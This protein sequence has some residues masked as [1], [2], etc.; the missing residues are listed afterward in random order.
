[1]TLGQYLLA[2][3]LKQ[4]KIQWKWDFSCVSDYFLDESPRFDWRLSMESVFSFTNCCWLLATAKF[5]CVRV[6]L[7]AYMPISVCAD[8]NATSKKYV[9][10]QFS[11]VIDG[12]QLK[13]IKYKFISCKIPSIHYNYHVRTP[14]YPGSFKRFAARVRFE[15]NWKSIKTQTQHNKMPF[16]LFY[17][18]E[19]ASTATIVLLRVVGFVVAFIWKFNSIPLRCI[20]FSFDSFYMSLMFLTFQQDARYMCRRHSIRKQS[21]SL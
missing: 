21:S 5:I 19:N 9:N 16:E 4:H 2:C 15:V 13:Y 7:S 11:Y 18:N 20:T 12:F 3:N 17:L 8:G 1:M 10:F 6:C 14:V